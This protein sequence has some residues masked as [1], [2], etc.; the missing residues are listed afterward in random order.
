MRPPRPIPCGHN[1]RAAHCKVCAIA[2][3]KPELN[4]QFALKTTVV[5]P[6]Q[7]CVHLG[8]DTGEVVICAEGC[9]GV[10]LK[11]F[12][13]S[14]FG[15]CTLAKR[16]DGVGACCNRCPKYEPENA[17]HRVLKAAARQIQESVPFPTPPSTNGKPL[18]WAYGIT[19]VPK[20]LKDGVLSLTLSS[21]RLAGFDKPRLFVD[22]DVPNAEW[23]SLGCEMSYRFPAVRTFGNWVMGMWELYLRQPH[24]DRYAIFQ[25]DMVTY[26]NLR[27]YL[28]HSTYPADGYLNLYTMPS[29]Q[30]IAPSTNGW[31]RA[32]FMECVK[33]NQPR[34]KT[35]VQQTGMCCG[36]R[37]M[38]YGRGAVALVFSRKALQTLL[39]SEHMVQRPTDPMR[40]HCAIDGGISW[41]MNKLGWY[42]YV[43]TPSLVQ[44]IGQQSTMGNKP[45]P[46]AN[47]FRGEGWDAMQLAPPQLP[48]ATDH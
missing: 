12:E 45:H 7:K 35:G 44:H 9:R 21:L 2:V 20:R 29:N 19:T 33:C 28:D 30:T 40:G 34:A 46:Q 48:T 47:S 37:A 11:V 22:G 39:A 16:G 18:E 24:A 43:H 8:D 31:Y 17:G 6:L 4:L 1:Q 32:L 3:A 5:P 36:E 26:T 38:Q 14:Q 10:K 13:C 42:E 27:A 15:V 25:D 23:A 41:A